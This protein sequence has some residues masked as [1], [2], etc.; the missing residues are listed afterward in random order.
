MA[1]PTLE[2]HRG[3]IVR[4]REGP[5]RR[6]DGLMV[7]GMGVFVRPVSDEFVLVVSEDL[8]DRRAGVSDHPV[9][10]DDRD[11]VRRVPDERLE[12]LV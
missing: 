1:I 11:H 8:L 6:P 9:G 2:A 3:L 10:V 12:S 7:V 4:F 5:K